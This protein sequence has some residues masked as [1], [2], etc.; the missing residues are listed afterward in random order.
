[1][2]NEFLKNTNQLMLLVA[3]SAHKILHYTT[4]AHVRL[5]PLP[6]YI[7]Q[8]QKIVYPNKSA[9]RKKQEWK[10]KK[11]QFLNSLRTNGDWTTKDAAMAIIT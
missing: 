4:T 7:P 11:N 3:V 6:L 8:I 10:K 2:K 1:M 9:N 5:N